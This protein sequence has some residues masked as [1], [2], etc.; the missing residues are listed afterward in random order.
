MCPALLPPARGNKIFTLEPFT[1]H[2]DV[3]E[4]WLRASF[5]GQSAWAYDA[6]LRV[7]NLQHREGSCFTLPRTCT[8]LTPYLP[9]PLLCLCPVPHPSGVLLPAPLRCRTHH[10]QPVG[11]LRHQQV[12][13]RGAVRSDECPLALLLWAAPGWSGQR[14]LLVEL[15]SAS[16]CCSLVSQWSG[17]GARL[18]PLW[19]DPEEGECI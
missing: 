14:G 5:C 10:K 6:G 9:P 17:T 7:S 15:H 18:A 3:V 1:P 8:H 11:S 19:E 12:C 2:S 16:L 13:E 4:Q